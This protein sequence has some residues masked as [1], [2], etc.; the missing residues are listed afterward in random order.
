MKFTAALE[1]KILEKLIRQFLQ[2]LPS[3]SENT[4]I[5]SEATC[6]QSYFKYDV[7]RISDCENRG[8]KQSWHVTY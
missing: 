8:L 6:G 5:E 2:S 1:N 3:T 4:D 7:H